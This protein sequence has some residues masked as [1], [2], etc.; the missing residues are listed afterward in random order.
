[1]N[2]PRIIFWALFFAAVVV[3]MRWADP[4]VEP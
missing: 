4:T 1:M 3:A 2:R